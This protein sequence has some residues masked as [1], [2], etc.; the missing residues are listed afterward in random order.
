MQ[1]AEIDDKALS[2]ARHTR[3]RNLAVS[4]VLGGVAKPNERIEQNKKKISPSIVT[5]VRSQTRDLVGRPCA[6]TLVVPFQ[7]YTRTYGTRILR[8]GVDSLQIIWEIVYPALPTVG[9]IY[10]L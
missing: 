5:L 6:P 8:R 10:K 1:L 2:S 4:R 9:S 7:Q 3:K